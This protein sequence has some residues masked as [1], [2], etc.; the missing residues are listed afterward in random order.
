MR[1]VLG[2]VQTALLPL[3]IPM[4]MVRRGHRNA[5][6]EKLAVWS[7][8]SNSKRAQPVP[9]PICRAKDVRAI[10]SVVRLAIDI[11]RTSELYLPQPERDV[12]QWTFADQQPSDQAA[13]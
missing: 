8:F 10:P 6:D 7:L 12:R 2:L 9:L 3:V 13:R 11:M 1:T 5:I 4:Q